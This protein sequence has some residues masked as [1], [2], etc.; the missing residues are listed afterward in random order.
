MYSL[1][2]ILFEL[3]QPFKTEMERYVSIE[4]LKNLY[5]FPDYIKNNWPQQVFIFFKIYIYS[6]VISYYMV[7]YIFK[8]ELFIFKCEIIKSL[9]SKDASQRPTALT[10]LNNQ[11]FMDA[12]Q[13]IN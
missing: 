1:G 5:E 7:I 2:I 9:L 3:Y 12:N 8:W 11:L 10:L 6:L 13:V 4:R